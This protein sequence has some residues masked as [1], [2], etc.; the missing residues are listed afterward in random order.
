MLTQKQENFCLAYIETGNASEAYRSAYNA[1]NMKSE[2]IHVKACELLKKGNVAVR[3][4][5]LRTKAI[6]RNEITVD[7]LVKELENARIAA[8]TSETVQ[9][10]AAIS[11]TMGKAKLLGLGVEKVDLTVDV[12]LADAIARAK[13]RI[14]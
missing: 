10:S 8:L 7:D 11:A 14:K 2:T 1:E 5:E 6:K 12:R 4:D 9:A 13:S 3:V